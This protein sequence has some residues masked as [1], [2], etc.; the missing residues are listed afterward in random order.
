MY[1]IERK[2]LGYGRMRNSYKCYRKNL[3]V[4]RMNDFHQDSRHLIDYCLETIS[5]RDHESIQWWYLHWITMD[6]RLVKYTD[7][8]YELTTFKFHS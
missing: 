1:Q 2:E 8:T 7:H 4:N 5:N 3:A 6:F